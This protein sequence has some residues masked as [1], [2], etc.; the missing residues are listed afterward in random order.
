MPKSESWA[1]YFFLEK[2]YKSAQILSTF[3]YDSGQ[4][5]YFCSFYFFLKIINKAFKQCF[6]FILSKISLSLLIK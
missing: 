3:I 6:L 4:K 5:K 2:F 1:F